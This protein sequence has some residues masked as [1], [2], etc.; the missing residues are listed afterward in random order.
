MP[1]E[2]ARP[3]IIDVA[4]AAG[5]SK[6]QVS[7][8]LRGDSGVSGESRDRVLAAAERLGYRKNGWAQRLVSGRS[9]LIGVLLTDLRNAY[10]TDIVN[11]IEDAA[12]EAGLGVLLRHGRRDRALLHRHLDELVDLGVDGVIAVTSHLP[13]ED[14]AAASARAP[15]VV[16]GRPVGVPDGVGQ[17]RNDDA[18]GARLATAH[19]QSLGHRRIAML[20]GSDRPAASARRDAWREEMAAAGVVAQEFDAR[21]RGVERLLA[22]VGAGEGPTAVFASNDRIAAGLLGE[23]LD[24]GL[25]APEDLAVVGYDNTELAGLLRP[26]LTSVD[27]PRGAMGRAAMAQLGELL[28]GRGVQTEVAAPSLVVRA[29]TVA[30][31]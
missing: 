28:A 29:S 11:G 14:L 5:V 6:S 18:A 7:A 10:H 8:A 23:A 19:L 26:G 3:T 31:R 25:A 12:A 13:P 24:R 30:G 22:A 2:S 20:R 16:V 4:R 27:Q 9:Q 21:D 1:P 17:V 15:M